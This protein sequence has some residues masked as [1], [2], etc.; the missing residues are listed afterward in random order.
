MKR[1]KLNPVRSLESGFGV[2]EAVAFDA[3]NRGSSGKRRIG[4]MGCSMGVLSRKGRNG[5]ASQ[6]L[7]SDRTLAGRA[8]TSSPRVT[9]GIER[10]SKKRKAAVSQAGGSTM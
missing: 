4:L 9:D 7:N 2:A 1:W 5:R 10:Q 8:R 6:A 3:G